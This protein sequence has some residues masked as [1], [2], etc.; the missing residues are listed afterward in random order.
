M[1]YHRGGD[2]M[3][4]KLHILYVDDEL[5]LLDIGKMFLEESGE[6]TV[7]T[8]D[9]AA[10]AL[11]L[12]RMEKFDAIVSDYQMPG[13]DGI[14]LLIEVR[15]TYGKIPFILFTGKGREDVV[16]QAINSGVDFYLQK[17]GEPCAQFAELSHKILAAFQHREDELKVTAINRLYAVL[18][19]TNKAIVRIHD[20]KALL[21]EVCRI[22]V[23]I[24]G[25][26][27]AW[28]GHV[29]LH[30]HFIEP[31][32]ASGHIDGYLDTIAIS[33]DDIF[34]GRGPTGTAYR[35][36]TFNVCNDVVNDPN[37]A[38]WREGALGRG[39]RSVAAFPYALDTRNA[40]VITVYAPEP[41][42]FTGQV[43]RLLDE[44]SENITFALAALDYEEQKR[45]SEE[46]LK[47]SEEKYRL[48]FTHL[49][50]G[51]ALHEIV[52]DDSGMPAD[53]RI[54]DVNPTFESILGLKREDVI[55]KTSVEAYGVDTPPFFDIYLRV[56]TTA[57]PEEF[58]TWFA[59]LEKYFTISAYSL[60]KGK[61]ATIFDDITRR[62]QVEDE[63]RHNLDEIKKQE[64]AL[65]E[66]EERY[67]S[68]Y[69]G[70][71]DAIM[72]VSPESG[73]LAANP[74][75]LE[76][77]ACR[78]EQ[79]FTSRTPASLS[80]DYQQDGMLSTEKSQEMMRLALANGSHFFEWTHRRGDGTEFPAKVL[81]SRFES[82][83]VQLLQATVRDVT[84]SKREEEAAFLAREEWELTFNAVPDLICILDSQHTIRRV[85]RAMAVKL[86]VTQEQATGLTCYRC[87]HGTQ[88]PPDFCPHT[89]LLEDLQEHTTELYEERLG[90]YFL[91][92]CTPL[93]DRN[94]R[95]IGSVH[96]AR[97]ITG[98]KQAEEELKQS[99]E[100]FRGIFD[101]INDGI[102]IHDIG[103]DGKPGK[104]I[105]VNDVACRM[106]G[107]T[108]DEMIEHGPL[109]FVTGYH[110]RPFDE[111][112]AEL[113]S[114]GHSVFETEH[115][116]KDGT[117]V[118]VEINAKVFSL[119]GKHVIVA[120][121]R[122]ITE[123]KVLD[124]EIVFHEQELLQFSKSLASAN[125]KLNLLGSITR[126]DITNQLMVLMGNIGI[127]QKK[128]PDAVFNT[129]L[130]KI[131]AAAQRISAMIQFT[132]EYEQ[133]G[134]NAPDW[135]D[136]HTIVETAAKQAPLAKVIVINDIPPGIA[137]LADPLIIKVFYNLMDNA[138]RYGGKITTIRFYTGNSGDCPLVICEDDGDGVPDEEKEKIFERGFG[139]NTGMGLFLSREILSITGITIRET[140]EPGSG[141]RFEMMVPDNACRTTC[142]GT[143]NPR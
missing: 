52:Y 1:A 8:T 53:Y 54:L 38:P 44:Q 77:F 30:K 121:V 29:N 86:G 2:L 18:S 7:T 64:L 91:V 17:G 122:D 134:I 82:G 119:Q 118:P 100:K 25:F 23:E 67:R 88:S 5:D 78:D 140:G 98:R 112:V 80:P 120:V 114:A 9:S 39:Y 46:A 124:E 4:E 27:M 109:D 128:Q 43:I 65:R 99:E 92:T 103:P 11:E 68:L 115:R 48:L 130:Q 45:E 116:R 126:H 131:S 138:V 32:A 36:R 16:V 132:K 22:V 26:R 34:P 12:I 47:K 55:G 108:H 66:N 59:P 87:V 84:D 95:L 60:G 58:E 107:Y 102:H 129:Y 117:L 125:K 24:G 135:Q 14:R 19:A 28:A 49:I 94:E 85:N 83:G 35:E 37:M 123:R 62:K 76:L 63:L 42:F 70:S 71:R 69:T 31:I 133:I 111:I 110:S 13:M 90:G 74:A 136:I 41:G 10:S 56:A 21:N 81:L 139:K 20:K 143:Q 113:R 51:S 15:A 127:L 79:D 73:F 142:T 61:F 75:T 93:F 97:D 40:G 104:F 33:T 72:I 50:A 3:T 137:V 141:A 89:R 96:V 6:F 106:L 101:T 57:V 105:A